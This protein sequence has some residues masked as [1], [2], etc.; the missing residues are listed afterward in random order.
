M[1][2]DRTF[3]RHLL[4]YLVQYRRAIR[5]KAYHYTHVFPRFRIDKATPRGMALL[6][7]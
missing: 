4:V 5:I 1:G 6:F 2:E 3:F 7:V